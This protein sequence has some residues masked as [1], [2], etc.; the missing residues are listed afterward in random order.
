M[1]TVKDAKSMAKSLRNALAEREVAL[2]HGECLEVVARQLG[3]ADWNTLAAK[4][5]ATPIAAPVRPPK[6]AASHAAG[7]GDMFCS[8][9]DK[10]QHEVKALVEGGCRSSRSQTPGCSFICDECINFSAQVLADR[11]PDD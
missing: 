9:C 2:S 3:F 4:L 8:F 10:S 7:H 5:P 1:S 11:M 6:T